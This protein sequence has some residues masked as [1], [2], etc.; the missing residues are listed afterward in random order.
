MAGS[1]YGKDHQL[2]RE[3]WRPAV[4]AGLEDCREPVCLHELDGL[5]RRIRPGSAWDLCHD[6]SGMV[7]IGPG[8]ERCNRS[9]GARRGHAQRRRAPRRWAL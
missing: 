4:E 3:A 6:P 8:H 1:K 7:V 5:G 9:E 2:E